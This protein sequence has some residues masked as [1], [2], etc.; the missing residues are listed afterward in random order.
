MAT[1]VENV[2]PLPQ[3]LHFVFLPLY[4][5]VLNIWAM[6]KIMIEEYRYY[7]QV[8]NN[9]SDSTIL[10]HLLLFLTLH[11]FVGILIGILV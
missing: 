5:M 11:M 3:H 1:L 8:N 6:I 7:F 9:V 2:I 10:I 4:E